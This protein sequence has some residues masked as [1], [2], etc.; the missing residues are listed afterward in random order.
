[1]SP[2]LLCYLA[3]AIP[4]LPALAFL[5][6]AS[7]SLAGLRLSER[8]VSRVTALALSSAFALSVLAA[9]G[10]L[11]L[12][13]QQLVVDLGAW[14]R[15][16]DLELPMTLLLDRLSVAM[17]V[18]SSGV[19]GLVGRF[20]VSYL[21]QE[22]RFLRFFGLLL[23]FTAGMLLV[24]LAG[25]LPLLFCGWELLGISASLLIGFF[26]ERLGPV[27]N[28]LRAFLC[29]RACDVGILLAIALLAHEGRD[30]GFAPSGSLAVDVGAGVGLLLTLGS[31]GKSA[32]LPL[33]GWLPRAMEGPTPSSALCYGALSVHAGVYL[34]LRCA[35]FFEASWVARGVLGAI[36]CATAV[37]ATLC[38]RVQTDVKNG[39]A[40]A[41]LTQVSLMLVEIALGLYSLALVHMLGHIALRTLQLLRAPTPSTTRTCAR[42]SS[43]PLHAARRPGW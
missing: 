37:W 18:V 3:P 16:A 10:V 5:L 41:S 39:L 43:G 8:F 1:M 2:E 42:R 24:V 22:R 38:A 25:N 6:L 35:P 21:H 23:L 40:F 19:C 9:Y 32:Q 13:T 20:A 30:V 36:A 29:Y 34:M 26:D 7:A 11:Q 31:L 17:A 27:R 4:A 33:S 14:F 28:A 15:S 12:P